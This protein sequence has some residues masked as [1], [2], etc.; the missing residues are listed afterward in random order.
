M[1]NFYRDIII[2]T[3]PVFFSNIFSKMFIVISISVFFIS[4]VIFQFISKIIL[5]ITFIFCTLVMLHGRTLTVI[6]LL[7]VAK[8]LFHSLCPYVRLSVWLRGNVI[9][10]LCGY[11]KYK[12]EILVQM[13]MT[14][15]SE[16][17]GRREGDPPILI[18][19]FFNGWVI[20]SMCYFSCEDRVHDLGNLHCKG[21]PY[22]LSGY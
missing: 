19:I 22:L 1:H 5:T 16:L 18:I 8:L 2:L 12:A 14:T 21:D 9:F 11:L 20:Y 15:L 13:A 3:I 10:F 17:E 7:V 4:R 6:L